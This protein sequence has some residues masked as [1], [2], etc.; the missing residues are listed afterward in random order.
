[1]K[2]R[3]MTGF[4]RGIVCKDSYDI[5]VE[6]KTVNHKF[7]DIRFK[8]PPLFST[9]EMKMKE[10]IQE[11]I[12]RGSV[13][14]LVSCKKTNDL[15]WD[16]L[17]KEKI[18]SFVREIKSCV[19]EKVVFGG[20]DFLQRDF[21]KRQVP[22]EKLEQYVLDCLYQAL[23]NLLVSREAEGVK[24]V[25]ILDKHKKNFQ[26]RFLKLKPLSCVYKKDLESR[27]RKQFSNLQ[28]ELHVDTPRFLQEMIYYLD[29]MDITEELDRIAGH[30]ER[31]G[32]S[33]KTGGELAENWI[34]LSRNSIVKQILSGPN[35]QIR[36]SP[37]LSSI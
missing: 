1:M 19:D 32:E 29:K 37:I 12:R 33:L 14:V 20:M 28:E 26:E 16:H 4:G 34:L 17:D 21:I 7:K 27:L 9:I 11:R 5:T 31:I 13:D 15:E 36:T 18:K 8:T 23:D 2:V 6:L 25:S 24:L 35:R 3:S 10:I 22:D 30:L